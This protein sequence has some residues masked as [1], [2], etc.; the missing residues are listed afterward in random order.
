[1]E[2][3]ASKINT[4]PLACPTGRFNSWLF[5][6]DA[7]RVDTIFTRTPTS[8]N[9]MNWLQVFNESWFLFIIDPKNIFHNKQ[10]FWPVSIINHHINRKKVGVVT[11]YPALNSGQTYHPAVFNSFTFRVFASPPFTFFFFFRVVKLKQMTGKLNEIRYC[12]V[13]CCSK[14]K[15]NWQRYDCF[16]FRSGEWCFPGNLSFQNFGL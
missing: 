14:K 8:W 3:E 12:P 10:N 11:L 6:A 5:V 9:F 4:G 2:N 13:C 16:T 15:K 1:M 7:G